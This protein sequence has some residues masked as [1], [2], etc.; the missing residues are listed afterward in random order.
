MNKV[1]IIYATYGSGH[2]A[3]AK[4]I[5]NY[6]Y[7]K[8]P[9]LEIKMID[10]IDYSKK[11]GILSKRIS[12]NLMLKMPFVWSALFKWADHKY[13]SRFTN[14]VSLNWF[15]KDDL[16]KDI[17]AFNPDLVISTHFYGS[18]F[19]S[20]LN[21]KKALNSK[22]ITVITDYEAHNIWLEHYI[23]GEYIV[24]PSKEEKKSLSKT[25]S[26]KYIKD[27]GI[28]IFPKA[29]DLNKKQDILK[30]LGFNICK[31]TCVCFSGG[32]NGS[33][34]TMPYIKA[35]LKAKADLNYIFISGNND[36]AYNKIKSLV[37]KYRIRNYKVYGFVNNVPELLVASDFVVTKPGGAQSTECLYFNKP[38]LFIKSS[39][40]QENDNISY[41][42]K[43]GFARFFKSPKKL[44][45]YFNKI[46]RNLSDINRMY[47]NLSKV[48]NTKAMK[49]LYSLSKEVLSSVKA[50]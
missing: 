6:F 37:K 31:K 27:F 10:M 32:G 42:T 24:V 41:F 34:A 22:L 15:S 1:L 38:M 48:D 45:K 40:G 20:R 19:I 47:Q 35:L 39:G 23:N 43:R 5:N 50:K 30:K 49:K 13:T 18:S 8:N 33:T 29:E 16:I 11:T 4:Y 28:P 25:I 26:K 14:R 12:E 36:K 2:K 44:Y 7:N 21:K 17:K 46:D 3:I 9:N